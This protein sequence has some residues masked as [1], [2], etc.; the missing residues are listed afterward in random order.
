MPSTD[1]TGEP[2]FPVANIVS[3]PL[4]TMGIVL[5][6]FD[7]LAHAMQRPE[8]ASPGRNYVLTP[9]QAHYLMQQISAALATRGNAPPPAASGPQH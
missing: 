8:A 3:G 9:V 2:L 5:I 1:L 6:R 7:F 4:V